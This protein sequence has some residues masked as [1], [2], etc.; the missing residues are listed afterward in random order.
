MTRHATRDVR[1]RLHRAG[2]RFAMDGTGGKPCPLGRARAG[3]PAGSVRNPADSIDRLKEH[4]RAITLR[5]GRVEP[6]GCAL[7][8]PAVAFV[9]PARALRP[10]ARAPGQVS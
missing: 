7:A 5:S 2:R 3:R 4:Q 9:S 1:H 10:V 8:P 6:G